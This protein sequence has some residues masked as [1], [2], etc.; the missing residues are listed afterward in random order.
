MIS[1]TLTSKGTAAIT[2]DHWHVV[3]SHFAG[4]GKD[5]R[6]FARAIV[7]EHDDR[8]GCRTA[9]K[10]LQNTIAAEARKVPAGKRDEVFARPPHFKSLKA[11]RRS[12][13]KKG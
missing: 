7:S 4:N 1:E 9:A 6:P 11:A 5:A 10:A 12:K 2:S 8:T 3:R 13:P